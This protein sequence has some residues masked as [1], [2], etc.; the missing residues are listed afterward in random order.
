MV[1]VDAENFRRKLGIDDD[2]GPYG[3]IGGR[4]GEEESDEDVE[5][6]GGNWFGAVD[7]MQSSTLNELIAFLERAGWRHTRHSGVTAGRGQD[8]GIN[9][10][11]ISLEEFATFSM[12]WRP[13]MLTQSHIRREWEATDLTKVHGFMRRL[14]GKTRG[15]FLL[16][17]KERVSLV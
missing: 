4:P 8:G 14:K 9:V 13:V 16:K 1:W 2:E 10:D 11:M 5:G 3:C 7:P 17:F 15:T 6:N 12:W